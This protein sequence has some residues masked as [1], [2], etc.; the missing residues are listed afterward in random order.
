LKTAAAMGLTLPASLVARADQV[1][2]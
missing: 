2:E 1:I